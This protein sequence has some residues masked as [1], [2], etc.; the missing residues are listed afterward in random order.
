METHSGELRATVATEGKIHRKAPSIS[1]TSWR[2]RIATM[3][4]NRRSD[5]SGASQRFRLAQGTIRGRVGF[6]P[7][8]DASK[9]RAG[10]LPLAA[11]DRVP[12]RTG[13]VE[14][15]ETAN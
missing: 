4:R 15:E 12:A 3:I 13:D 10:Q 11:I 14:Q 6:S 2:K 7:A 5:R 9:P 8:V 1:H